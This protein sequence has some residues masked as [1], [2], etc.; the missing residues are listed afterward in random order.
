MWAAKCMCGRLRKG[1]KTELGDYGHLIVSLPFQLCSAIFTNANITKPWTETKTWSTTSDSAWKL[2]HGRVTW[3]ALPC[4]VQCKVWLKAAIFQS[5][6]RQRGTGRGKHCCLLLL[7]PLAFWV[8]TRRER[9]L[10][11]ELC[12][13]SCTPTKSKSSKGVHLHCNNSYDVSQSHNVSRQK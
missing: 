12:R 4:S 1:T 13:L 6:P 3:T 9:H 2:C 5:K 8:H 10:L 11:K 7:A